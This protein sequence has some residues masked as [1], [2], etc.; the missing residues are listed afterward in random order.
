MEKKKTTMILACPVPGIG[1]ALAQT[2]VTGTVVNSEDGQPVI[3]VHLSRLL[4]LT[5][6][7]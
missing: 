2:Q 3:S 6:A 5:L 1:M 4:V 7:Q